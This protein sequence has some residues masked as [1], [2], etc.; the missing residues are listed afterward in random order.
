MYDRREEIQKK[1]KGNLWKIVFNLVIGQP[2]LTNCSNI[3]II[4]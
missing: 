2:D 3:R 1:A 4:S